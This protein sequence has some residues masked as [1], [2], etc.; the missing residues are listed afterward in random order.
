MNSDNDHF[1]SLIKLLLP[2]EIFE[3][4]VITEVQTTEAEIHVKLDELNLP[5]DG[6][7][8]CCLISK[9]FH[10]ASKIQDFPL[11]ERAMFL[12]VRRRRW[13]DSS[14]GR[15]ISRDWKSVA[16]GTRMTSGFAAFLKEISRH[17]SNQ[18]QQP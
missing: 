6:F 14:S 10:K 16:D 13:L 11:R 5:P 17:I 4:F 18:Q 1:N 3:Y 7:D 2:A 12:H 9:G 8:A 15:L